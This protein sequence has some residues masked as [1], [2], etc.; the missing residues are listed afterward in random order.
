MGQL[1]F[2]WKNKNCK[3]MGVR[4]AAPVSIVRPEERVQHIQIPGRSGD[5]TETEGQDIYNSYI[6][7]A[8]IQVSGGFRAR[9]IYDWLRGADY[10]TFHGE[11]DRKQAARIIGAVTLNKFSKNMDIWTGEVQ[12][13]CQPLK[14]LLAD[15]M[16]TITSSGTSVVNR[17][18]VTAKPVWKVTI[19]SN[20]TSINLAAGGKT[21][22]VTGLT[23][24]NVIW[25]DSEIMEVWNADGTILM[26]QHSTGEFPVLLQGANSVTGSGWSKIEIER[27]ER[28]L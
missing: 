20:S 5:L 1:F 23:A 26:T 14:Q 9:E 10:V 8:S 18:D 24:G 25:I 12:F 15:P 22:T 28:F 27:R 6:Q 17:G 21:L 11:P 2:I 7:T 19:G 16:V 4:L 3:N 13:Y